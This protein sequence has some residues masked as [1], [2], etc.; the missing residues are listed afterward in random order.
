[1]KLLKLIWAALSGE[2]QDYTKTAIKTSIVLLA[3]PMI[4]EMMM[5]SIFTVVDMFFV[6]KLG[7]T[8]LATVGLT[9][10]IMM[11]IYSI[12]M[13]ISMA[14]IALVSRRFGEKNYTE[15]GT[16]TF[17]FI[18]TGILLSL[19]IGF[20]TTF[21]AEELLRS[22][23]ASDNV[24]SYGISYSRIIF[25]GNMAILMLFLING[26]FRGAGSPSIAMWSLG[27]GNVTNMV[28]DPILIFGIGSFDG[29]GL[30]GAA[31]A[32]TIGRSVGV[33]YQLYHLLNGKHLLKITKENIKVRF[34]QIKKIVA[35][36][37]GGIG[38]FLVDSISWV[39]VTRIIALFG[40]DA[41]A[42]YTIAF[43]VI[44]FTLLPAWGLSSAA[45]T[46]VGQNLGARKIKRAEVAVW[47]TAKYN[48][49]FLAFITVTF[50]LFG[51]HISDIFTND[52]NV[53]AIASEAL[54]II[55]LGYIFFG[56][57]MVMIQAFNG[58]GDTKTP[59]IVNIMVLW[60]FEV[61][62]AY[63][64]GI[65]FDLGVTG[66]FMAVAIGHSTHAILSLYL[67]KKGKWKE[68]SV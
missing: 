14:A 11:I 23:G 24:I 19:I 17:Q 12:G 46:L 60:L 62:L 42:A 38:Q 13:G 10:S 30:E 50:F 6:G 43:R 63:T 32:S 22:M 36:S 28:L 26:A 56:L 64:L 67:F 35:V 55:T 15:A 68:V 61:P 29:M 49:L 40:D 2:E 57:G 47:V 52:P 66:V 51:S 59:T 3:T 16:V 7:P 58:A 8:A 45:A 27:I 9:E 33:I 1:M 20:L 65:I 18:L 41:M 5:E 53:I 34:A 37:I 25:I 4:M 44:I 21:F 31:W 48:M 39:L 54:M